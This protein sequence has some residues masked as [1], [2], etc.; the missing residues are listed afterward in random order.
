MPSEI[1]GRMALYHTS[2]GELQWDET[3]SVGYGIDVSGDG[4]ERPLAGDRMN[5]KGNQNYPYGSRPII[6]A[7]RNMIFYE[8]YMFNL[9]TGEQ[10]EIEFDRA[11]NCGTT[12]ASANMLVYRS[13]T[14]GYMDMDDWKE[15]TK[16]WGGFRPACWLNTIPAGGIV[17]IPQGVE[18]CDC[19]YLMQASVALEPI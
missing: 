5:S 17:L 15:G 6:L 19:S 4:V 18:D 11:Y 7:D 13:A 1:G 12:A 9:M 3:V 14:L 10:L 2:D 8:P 16:N